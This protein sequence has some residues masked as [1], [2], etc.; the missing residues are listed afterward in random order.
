MPGHA[1]LLFWKQCEAPLNAFE[2]LSLFD[3]TFVHYSFSARCPFYFSVCASLL[4]F[5][6]SPKYTGTPRKHLA[7]IDLT[8]AHCY[9][10][11]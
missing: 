8:K 2:M 10:V 4:L 1:R 3:V 6:P 9:M 7:V 11:T 5:H